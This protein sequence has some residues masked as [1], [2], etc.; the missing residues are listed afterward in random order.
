MLSRQ[1]VRENPDEIRRALD[2]KGVEFDLDRLLDVDEEWRTLK[3]EGDD[4]RRQRNEISSEIGELKRDGKDE[5]ADAAIERSA[6][7]KSEIEAIEARAESLESELESAL[8]ELPNVPH[9]EAP[10][11]EDEADNIERERWGF[12]DRR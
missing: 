2:T 8:L 3:A 11:G 10:V 6:E 1:F 5:A 7:L 9:P 4:L 12:D